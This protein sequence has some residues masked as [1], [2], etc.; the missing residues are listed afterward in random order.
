[1]PRSIDAIDLNAVAL[2]GGVSP[3]RYWHQ[4]FHFPLSGADIRHAWRLLRLRGPIAVPSV[5]LHS[6]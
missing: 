1:M 3:A 4:S 5:R 6:R 2:N